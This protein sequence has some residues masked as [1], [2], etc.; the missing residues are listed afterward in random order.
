MFVI[1]N[2]KFKLFYF[3]TTDSNVSYSILKNNN[4]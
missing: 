2:L 3:L 1:I 4:V